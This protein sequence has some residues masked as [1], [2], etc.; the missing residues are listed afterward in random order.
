VDGIYFHSTTPHLLFGV[1]EGKCKGFYNLG[2][3]YREAYHKLPSIEHFK[4]NKKSLFLKND[5]SGVGH[6]YGF[7]A[8][9]YETT[10]SKFSP[11]GTDPG[12]NVVYA[13]PISSY[14]EIYIEQVPVVKHAP[15]QPEIVIYED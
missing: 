10:N 4:A 7:G 3:T 8:Q 13:Y 14:I 15:P 9:F 11:T 6:W 5:A 2:G 1:S 12:L